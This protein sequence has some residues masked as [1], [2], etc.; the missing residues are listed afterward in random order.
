M[1]TIYGASDLDVALQDSGVTVTVGSTTG[2]GLVDVADDAL[3]R[4]EAADLVGKLV[5]VTVKTGVFTLAPKAA[6]TADSV[7]YKIHSIDRL[8][9]GAYT[10]VVCVE[11]N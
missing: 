10:R 8:D 11:V 6:L 9:D 7:A 4:Q 1:A 2:R 3:L 5:V